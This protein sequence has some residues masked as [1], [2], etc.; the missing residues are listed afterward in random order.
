MPGNSALTIPGRL[1]KNT[2]VPSGTPCLVDTAA[3]NNLT[4]GVSVNHCLAHP[5]GNVVPV[6]MINQN[7]HI[8]IQQSVL[9]AEVF[10]VEHLP[11]DYGVEFHQEGDKI[12]VAFQPLPMADIIASVKAIHK[13]PDKVPLKDASQEPHLT[14]GPP[15]QHPS[16]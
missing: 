9:A 1:G 10:W 16:G 3:V 4:H 7:N 12:D 5:K 14:F 13:E 8:W 15:S 11:Q 2:K 6:I